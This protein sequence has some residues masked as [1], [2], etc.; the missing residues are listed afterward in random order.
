MG[1][2]HWAATFHHSRADFL[3]PKVS[4]HSPILVSSAG[5]VQH[6]KRFRFYNHWADELDFLDVVREA[7]S[8]GATGDPMIR[9][10]KKL[11]SVKAALK[12]WSRQRFGHLSAEQIHDAEACGPCIHP[13][14]ENA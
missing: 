6:T 14:S 12:P 4:D 7:W 9:F 1:N 10:S 11:K 5:K 3:L 2:E 8:V 13:G